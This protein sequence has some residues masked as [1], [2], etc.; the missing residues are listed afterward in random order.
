MTGV[1]EKLRRPALRIVAVAVL[2]LALGA[3]LL[4]AGR[5]DD[6]EAAHRP[7]VRPTIL[8]LPPEPFKAGLPFSEPPA[9]PRSK[10]G[11]RAT[12]V[13]QNGTVPVSGIDVAGTQTYSAAWSGGRRTRTRILAAVP[14]CAA[15]RSA[16]RP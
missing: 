5:D 11:L 1:L 8:V 14:G 13:A 10:R 6:G 15:T 3:G 4:I 16:G 12:L 9:V 2:A 7:A